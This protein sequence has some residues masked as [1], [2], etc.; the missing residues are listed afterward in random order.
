LE[1]IRLT[2]G[3]KGSKR[4]ILVDEKGVPLAIILSGAN[5]HDSKLLDETLRSIVISRAESVVE[6]LCLDA[7]YVGTEETI[8]EYGYIAHIRPI[9][10]SEEEKQE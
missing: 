2:G 1:G 4:S 9:L 5:I 10:C 8:K 6:N 3:K 7:G